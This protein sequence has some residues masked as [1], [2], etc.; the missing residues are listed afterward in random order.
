MFNHLHPN[1]LKQSASQLGLHVN[2]FTRLLNSANHAYDTI[3]NLGPFYGNDNVK[4]PTFR[5]TAEPVRMPNG[6]KEILQQFGSDLLYLSKA[7]IN[8]PPHYKDLLG[9]ELDF[10]IPIMWRID[11]II[12]EK[13]HIR[14][15]EIEGQDGASALMVAEQLAYKLQTPEETTIAKL[16]QTL[17]SI[18]PNMSDKHPIRLAILRENVVHGHGTAN[19]KRFISFMQTMSKNSIL[20]DLLDE[21]EVKTGLVI[22]DWQVYKGILNES[23][24]SP[25]ELRN[26]G[27]Q[28]WQLIAAG[29]Y[30]GL[31]N[32]GVYAFLY[33]KSLKQF[34][35][36]HI[37]KERLERLQKI[38]IPTSFVESVE[39]IEQCRKQ[40]RVVKVSWAGTNTQLINRSRGVALPDGISESNIEK[41]EELRDLIKQNVRIIAQDFIKPARIHAFLRKR[42]TTLEPVDWFNRVCVKYVVEENPNEDTIPPV[43]LTAVEV[44]LGPEIIPAGRKCTFTAGTFR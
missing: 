1:I 41:W 7:L 25:Q 5:I 11:A 23:S 32:K 40:G 43:A 4:E 29:N 16:I 33:E 9:K 6:S 8:L 3:T 27:M 31:S 42:G 37:G 34:W 36:K 19:T 2:E 24:I 17:K 20:I 10:K 12:D 30:C 38:F 18:Y 21:H 26:L 44:T 39:D 35:E 14:V 22:P 13:G 15:N 28:E